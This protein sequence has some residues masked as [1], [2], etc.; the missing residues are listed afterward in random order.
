MVWYENAK[1]SNPASVICGVGGDDKCLAGREILVR[2]QGGRKFRA[3]GGGCL[4]RS[5]LCNHIDN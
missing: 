4:T 5:G 1:R 3:L 2:D